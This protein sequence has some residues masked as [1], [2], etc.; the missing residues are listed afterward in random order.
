MNVTFEVNTYPQ[1]QKIVQ[2]IVAQ[3]GDHITIDETNPQFVICVGG[4]GTFLRSIR[5]FWKK[6][7]KINFL[8]IHTGTL[9]FY[10]DYKSHEIAQFVDAF[11]KKEYVIK[12]LDVLE[13]ALNNHKYFALNDFRI[14]SIGYTAILDVKVN[15]VFLEQV[16]SNGINFSTQSGSTAY[17]KSLGGAILWS[18]VKAFQMRYV[19]PISNNAYH[20]I[21][22]PIVFAK[23]DKIK[24]Q[25]VITKGFFSIDNYHEKVEGDLNIEVK[26][27]DEKINLVQFNH[28]NFTKR[29]R[30]AFAK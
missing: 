3:L 8:A 12:K 6:R 30:E 7:H 15:D 19:A 18:S 28:Y 11:V 22:S 13:I 20:S 25:G 29:I 17:N 23:G 24:C 27:S 4:D 14:E 26:L 5:K 2:D 21:S 10:S 16:R 9:G 1:S